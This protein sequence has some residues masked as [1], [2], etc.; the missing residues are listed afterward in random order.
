LITGGEKR[1][2]QQ[3]FYSCKTVLHVQQVSGKPYIATNLPQ[4]TFFAC[5]QQVQQFNLSS[6]NTIKTMGG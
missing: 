5:V 6:P 1:L 2:I 3:L 4:H